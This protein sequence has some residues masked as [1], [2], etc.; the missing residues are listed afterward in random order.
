MRALSAEGVLSLTPSVVIAVEG[1][2]PAEAI[3][4]LGKASVPFVLVPEAHDAAGVVAKI[5]LSPDVVGEAD[6]GRGAR[7]RG[8]R[9]S[10][11]RSQPM[12]ATIT[13]HRKAIFVL[14]MSAARRLV[15]G[16][17]TA[18]DGIFALAGVDNALSGID[19]LQA[20]E[21]RGGAGRRARRRR[22]HGGARAMT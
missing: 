7:R 15:A 13:E 19:R 22:H 12:R 17:S 16:S 1:S 9:G 2:G 21:R 3:E 10:R 5:R 18:A 4:V 6:E 8:R 11:H 14:G 20:G